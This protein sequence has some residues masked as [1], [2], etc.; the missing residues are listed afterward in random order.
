MNKKNFSEFGVSKDSKI[1][2]I[3]PSF[4]PVYRKSDG[5][6]VDIVDHSTK[7]ELVKKYAVHNV[8]VDA[9][10]DVDFVC[11]GSYADSIPHRKY[12]DVIMGSHIIEHMLDFI[13]FFEDCDQLLNYTGIVKLAVPDSRYEFDYFRENSSIRSVMDTHSWRLE[14]PRTAHT[15]GATA[16]NQMNNVLIP[17]L[18]TYLPDSAILRKD[19]I[20]FPAE[21]PARLVS[22][23]G[24]KHS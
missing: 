3:G 11:T 21:N 23:G 2:E 1:L 15:M 24:G 8:N 12:Y 13:G 22:V 17:G 6:N 5:W 10:E 18:G 9:I 20:C 4:N 7:S 16:E 14:H 19:K